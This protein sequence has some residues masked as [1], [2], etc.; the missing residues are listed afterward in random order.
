M[1]PFL[2][3]ALNALQGCQ[4]VTEYYRVQIEIQKYATPFDIAAL[5]QHPGSWP[6]EFDAWIGNLHSDLVLATPAVQDFRLHRLGDA[7]N[8]YSGP[9][10]APHLI[11][12]FCGKADLLF[13]PIGL[14]LQYFSAKRHVLLVLRD[15]V[16]A[17]FIGGIAGHSTTFREMID[18][19][20][21]ELDFSQFDSI[22]TFGSS[23]GGGAALAAGLLLDASSAV[24]FS[25]HL[26]SA[27]PRY[28]S[29]AASAALERILRSAM[30]GPPYACVYSASN[31]VD[32]QNAAALASAISVRSVRLMPVAGDGHNVIYPLHKRRQLASL[33]AMTGLTA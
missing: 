21:R 31:A 6:G 11:V 3:H 27:S 30:P 20:R 22:R 12:A 19:L 9:S 1:S 15:P 2:S 26:P 14:M 29:E 17:G 18:K 24:S 8:L 33:L 23:G 5:G 13:M 25:G 28:G 4:S 10:R 16:R 7:V 32:S